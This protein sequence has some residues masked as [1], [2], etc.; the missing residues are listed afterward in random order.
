MIIIIT[1]LDEL[2]EAI[3]SMDSWTRSNRLE[4]RLYRAIRQLNETE[5]R[6]DRVEENFEKLNRSIQVT[7]RLIDVSSLFLITSTNERNSWF[8][9]GNFDRFISRLE[10]YFQRTLFDMNEKQ[11]YIETL[12]SLQSLSLIESSGLTKSIK[13]I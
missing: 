6:A 4:E 8:Q 1:S 7:S 3:L 2:L 5:Q 11:L 12:F 13:R 10:H 9:S